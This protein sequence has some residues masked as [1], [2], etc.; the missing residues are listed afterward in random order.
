MRDAIVSCIEPPFAAVVTPFYHVERLPNTP[1]ASNFVGMPVT[2]A[3]ILHSARNSGCLTG[4]CPCRIIA[5]AHTAPYCACHRL[6][7]TLE[8]V[9]S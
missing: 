2:Y 4:S 7:L 5:A 1:S 9:S 6:Q 8:S 3:W